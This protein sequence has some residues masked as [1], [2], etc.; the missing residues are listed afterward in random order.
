MFV[1]LKNNR[2]EVYPGNHLALEWHISAQDKFDMTSQELAIELEKHMKE[3]LPYT[4]IANI[5][6]KFLDTMKLQKIYKFDLWS[7]IMVAESKKPFLMLIGFSSERD[8]LIGK[9]L[10]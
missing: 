1:R 8:L 4:F 10:I 9:M 5:D 6:A 2:R 3:I 7:S